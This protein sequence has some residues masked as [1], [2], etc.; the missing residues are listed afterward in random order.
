MG[1][2]SRVAKITPWNILLYNAYA[3]ATEHQQMM[4]TEQYLEYNF[5]FLCVCQKK[6][7]KKRKKRQSRDKKS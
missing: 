4:S 3:L 7:K 6:A 1:K 5:L 2:Y